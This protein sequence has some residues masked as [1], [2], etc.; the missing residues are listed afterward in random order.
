MLI[1][2]VEGLLRMLDVPPAIMSL[3]RMGNSQT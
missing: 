1:I 3:S 2:F